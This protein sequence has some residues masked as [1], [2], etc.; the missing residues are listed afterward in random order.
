MRLF[1][2]LITSHYQIFDQIL[3]MILGSELNVL[4][5]RLVMGHT[6]NTAN[7]AVRLDL[8]PLLTPV[9]TFTD[10][11]IWAFTTIQLYNLGHKDQVYVFCDWV[12]F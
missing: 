5:T 4:S 8:D 2:W 10:D 7:I 11:S 12:Q 1:V 6:P 9:E 3:Q